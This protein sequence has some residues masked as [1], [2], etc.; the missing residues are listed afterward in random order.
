MELL[1][2]SSSILELESINV[3]HFYFMLYFYHFTHVFKKGS[4][5]VCMFMYSIVSLT[6]Y[7]FQF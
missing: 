7:Y 6:S 3:L 4:H 5:H 2:H 1:P